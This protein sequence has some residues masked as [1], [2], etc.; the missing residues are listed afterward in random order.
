MKCLLLL[1]LIFFTASSSSL[2]QERNDSIKINLLQINS[3]LD[4]QNKIDELDFYLE[5]NS[6]TRDIVFDDNRET[7]WL[8]TYQSLKY[9]SSDKN[10]SGLPSHI[11]LPLYREYL[12]NSKFNPVREILGMVQ[13]GAAGYL[14]YKSVKKHGLFR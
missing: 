1:V 8:W 10:Y 9:S 13:T 11:S 6:L 2:S 3:F 14:I 7:I 12:E 5:L 4:L